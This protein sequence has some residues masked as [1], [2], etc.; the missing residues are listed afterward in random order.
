MLEWL[1]FST[2]GILPI[3]RLNSH[4]LYLLHWQAD[5]LPLSPGKSLSDCKMSDFHGSDYNLWEVKEI[6]TLNVV[7]AFRK[8]ETVK[9]EKDSFSVKVRRHV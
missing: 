5:S 1:P 3:Q 4:L 2:P 8:V 7:Y 6:E 9:T